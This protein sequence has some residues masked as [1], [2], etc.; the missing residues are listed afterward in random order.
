MLDQ[1]YTRKEVARDCLRD[2]RRKTDF[3]GGASFFVE[4]SAGDGAFYDLLPHGRKIGLDMDP[5]HA[6]ILRRDFLQ[7]R[8]LLPCRSADAVVVGNPPF[9]KRGAMAVR[10]FQ[11]AAEIADTI[12]FIVP[13]IFR[14]HFI[15]KQLPKS[16]RWIHAKPL[17]REAFVRPN[18]KV[19]AV[20]TE[21]QIW[22]RT[23]TRHK[24]RRLFAPPPIKHDDF[25]MWQYN[26]T[27][28]A[29]KVFDNDFDF[30]V[31][32]QGWQDYTRR[33]TDAKHCERRK[34]WMLLKP[35]TVRARDLLYEGIDYEILAI[36]HTTTTPGFRKGDLIAE[37][38]RIA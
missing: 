32:C 18:G 15:H 9:G 33:E 34:Q 13:V 16:W 31:P 30:A 6:D 5:R 17:A 25:D 11:K 3:L 22:T 23:P 1:F 19:Y 8:D 10:F 14:K 24:N 36:K 27:R 38:Q 28:E 29:L 37:Y 12:A 4:P 21:F 26:N 20:N 35:K 7:W 2:F